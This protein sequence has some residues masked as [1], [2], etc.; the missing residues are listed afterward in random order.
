MNNST[1]SLLQNQKKSWCRDAYQMQG[2]FLYKY[3]ITAETKALCLFL[4]LL[5][6]LATGFLLVVHGL[7]YNINILML[8]SVL[9]K[10]FMLR[11]ILKIISILLIS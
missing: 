1:P 8:V 10:T 6:Y 7:I 4:M 2:H 5:A 9:T 11:P 3:S